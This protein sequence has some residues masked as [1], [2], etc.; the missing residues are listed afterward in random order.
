MSVGDVF[1][2]TIGAFA[3][4]SSA[5]R[6]ALAISAA[7]LKLSSSDQPPAAKLPKALEPIGV[8]DFNQQ[9]VEAQRQRITEHVRFGL[10]QEGTGGAIAKLGD[11]ARAG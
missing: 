9:D 11:V 3:R 8:L 2:A 10:A 7:I 6:V 1:T 5:Y 4:P